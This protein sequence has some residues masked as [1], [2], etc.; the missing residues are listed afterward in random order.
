VDWLAVNQQASKTNGR[1]YN[2]HPRSNS[3][4]L[5]LCRYIMQELV[6]RSEIIR[7]NARQGRIA[8]GL[9]IEHT[10]QNGK[11]KK[12]ELAIGIPSEA[13]LAL[14]PPDGGSTQVTAFFRVLV[15]CEVHD[16]IPSSQVWL[17]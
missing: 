17:A 6:T 7:K 16:L 3:H 15:S 13:T 10:F 11:R 9:D 4:S 1:L 5:W 8:L 14:P 2:Y 12:L